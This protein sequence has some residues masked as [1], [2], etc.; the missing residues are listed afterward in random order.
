MIILQPTKHIFSQFP[1]LST[2]SLDLREIKP[3]EVPS[4]VDISFYDG[5]PATSEAEALIILEK[6]HSDYLQG[7]SIH[8]GI[9][10]KDTKD[11]LGSCTFYGGYPDNIAEVGYVLKEAYRAKGIMHQALT[12]IV[13]FGLY[14]M[15]LEAIIAQVSPD[16][17]ASRKLL[18]K[19][20][21]SQISSEDSYLKFR[22]D[23]E[24]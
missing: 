9:C 2:A 16:N 19:T 22:I 4:I 1:V 13:H 23:K 12:R 18:L 10:L 8:W 5:V 14:E 17:L 11:I 21:F 7:E 15:N 6:I 3:S 24:S 20:G